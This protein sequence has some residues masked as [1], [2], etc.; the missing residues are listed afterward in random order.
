MRIPTVVVMSGVSGSGKSTY[1]EKLLEQSQGVKVSTDHFFMVGNEYKFDPSKLGE[2][3]AVGWKPEI[4]TL[5]ASSI[6]K[7]GKCAERNVH[8]V[9]F[10]S[11][12]NQAVKLYNRKLPPYWKNTDI[13]AE[14]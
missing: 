12:Q 11:V 4:I 9:P 1:A 7:I 13:A 6:E 14:L 10:C 5:R 2:A 3:H 8:R